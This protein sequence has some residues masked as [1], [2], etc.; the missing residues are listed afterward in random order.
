MSKAMAS[1]PHSSAD[2]R[3]T[4]FDDLIAGTE[5][6]VALFELINTRLLR[7]CDTHG[8]SLALLL[9]VQAFVTA[10][11]Q[12]VSASPVPGRPHSLFA[13]MASLLSL[14]FQQ[15]AVYGIC[16]L[17]MKF[18]AMCF[19]VGISEHYCKVTDRDQTIQRLI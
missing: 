18:E 8:E 17:R 3:A 12:L 13:V 10:P 7:A 1:S 11:L 15:V 2:S 5:S 9:T 19:H 16:V 14:G 6:F 4:A